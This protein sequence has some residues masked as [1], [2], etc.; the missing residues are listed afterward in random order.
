M[1]H[2]MNCF[3]DD[4]DNGYFSSLIIFK[5]FLKMFFLNVWVSVVIDEKREL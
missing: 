1:K 3:I 2:Y 5:E 4:Q